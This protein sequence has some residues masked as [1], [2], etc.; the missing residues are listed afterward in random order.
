MTNNNLIF[1]LGFHNG[2]DTRYYLQKGF[3]VVAV[4][5]NLESIKKSKNEFESLIKIDK[6]II[7]NKAISEKDNKKV[8]F[9]IHPTKDYWSSCLLGMTESDGS[10]STHIMVDSITLQ[11][12][13]S[14]YGIPYYLK[15]DIEGYDVLVAKQ[16]FEH[17]LS[18]KLSYLKPVYVSFE[19]SRHNYYEIF[20]Y[21]YISGYRQF[22]LVN[23]SNNSKREIDINGR[24]FKFSEH[25]SGPFGDDLPKDKWLSFDE[26]L[27]R[28]IKY[29]ELKERDNME[30]GI[31]WIDV[32][33]K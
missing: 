1:D 24:K 20:S 2:D 14:T 16:L 13:F 33:A 10:K 18:S 17:C 31:G 29:K 28:Y 4:E 5:A 30:L 11:R 19:I 7:L 8:D 6:L 26:L 3:N 21:L 15:V 12:L 9:Y 27:T 23:Q 22:Q 32:H 25:S